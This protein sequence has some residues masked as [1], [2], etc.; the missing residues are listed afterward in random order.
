M[1]IITDFIYNNFSNSLFSS[2]S[3]SNL[4]N[5][6]ITLVLKIKDHENVAVLYC[7]YR[8]ISIFL[9]LWKVYVLSNVCKILCKWQ[10]DFRQRYST[11]HWFLIIT[12]KLRQCLDKGYKWSIRNWSLKAFYYFWHDLFI[13][14]LA[15]S[16]FDYES[17]VFMLNYLFER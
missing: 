8:T 1:N 5:V 10:C 13:A 3:L 6:D 12:E 4:K 11:Q 14:K 9:V 17:L 7:N 2:Y 15:V 16:G